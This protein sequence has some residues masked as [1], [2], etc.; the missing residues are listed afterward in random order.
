MPSADADEH[1]ACAE[2]AE[3]QN[4]G[5]SWTP[6]ATKEQFSEVMR[7]FREGEERYSAN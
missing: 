5:I 1:T 3:Y 7:D 2:Q 6:S 4:R